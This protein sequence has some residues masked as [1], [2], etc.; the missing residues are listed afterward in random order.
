MRLKP[1]FLQKIVDAVA[2][3]IAGEIDTRDMARD[4]QD[5]VEERLSQDINSDAI[6]ESVI[7][8]AIDEIDM[9]AIAD[10][11]A[12]KIIDNLEHSAVILED[13]TIKIV[14]HIMESGDDFLDRLARITA[15]RI[16]E[17]FLISDDAELR[18]RGDGDPLQQQ[19]F[20]EQEPV[21]HTAQADLTGPA[22]AC[23]V[24]G[25][26][27]FMHHDG[28]CPTI[29]GVLDLREASNATP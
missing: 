11:V 1:S 26:S 4:I 19:T 8:H 22:V 21:P 29:P 24:C 13:A 23:L 9:D 3:E 15:S 5:S 28:K 14:E 12:E 10:Q 7:E 18:L 20:Q 25:G 6:T 16:I 17:S 2:E 27:D